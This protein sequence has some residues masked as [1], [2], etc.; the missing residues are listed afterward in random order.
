[1]KQLNICIAGLGNVGS[2]LI[3]SIE[4]NNKFHFEDRSIKINI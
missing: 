1:M 3:Q 2:A 4:D